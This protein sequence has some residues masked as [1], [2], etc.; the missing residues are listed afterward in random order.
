MEE[1]HSGFGEA[2]RWHS[3]YS[4]AK[5][6][7]QRVE[8]WRGQ[9]ERVHDQMLGTTT[10]VLLA[11]HEFELPHRSKISVHRHAERV[12]GNTTLQKLPGQ[13]TQKFA[14]DRVRPK[15]PRE[16]RR[17]QQP[18]GVRAL[19]LR[20]PQCRERDIGQR[21]GRIRRGHAV[22]RDLSRCIVQGHGERRVQ[23]QLFHQS[24][25]LS[26]IKTIYFTV[27]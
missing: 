4:P 12:H 11:H 20:P 5:E 15:R 19:R 23:I 13:L 3:R 21:T 16:Q 8:R 9:P 24:H 6:I 18:R 25:H 7:Q 26:K 17:V 14:H 2:A 1:G 10:L 22:L 27:L